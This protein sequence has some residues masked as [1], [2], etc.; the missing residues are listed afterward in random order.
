MSAI[1]LDPAFEALD[2]CDKAL[3]KLSDSCCEPGRSP[4]M[5]GLAE[6]LNRGRERLRVADDASDPGQIIAEFE[7]AGAQIGHLQITCCALNRM[8]LYADML[9][10]LTKAQ[11]AVTKTYQLGH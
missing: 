2:K 11:R 8:P 1:T 6:T 4:R 9:G 5:A 10:E 3:Q 7:D